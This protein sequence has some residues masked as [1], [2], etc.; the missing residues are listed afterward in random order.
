MCRNAYAIAKLQGHKFTYG[1]LGF[2]SPDHDWSLANGF[3]RESE[4]FV[5]DREDIKRL[6][7]DILVLLERLSKLYE[8]WR[9][10]KNRIEEERKRTARTERAKLKASSDVGNPQS[11]GLS[12]NENSGG[13]YDFD[14]NVEENVVRSPTKLSQES[15]MFSSQSQDQVEVLEVRQGV[16]SINEENYSF[17]KSLGSPTSSSNLQISDTPDKTDRMDLES[18]ASVE[19]ESNEKYCSVVEKLAKRHGGTNFLAAET[20]GSTKSV[21]GLSKVNHTKKKKLPTLALRS[22]NAQ[23]E[24]HE[25]ISVS[26]RESE[27]TQILSEQGHDTD[28]EVNLSQQSNTSQSTDMENSDMPRIDGKSF[29]LKGRICAIGQ[30]ESLDV[31]GLADAAAGET[32]NDLGVNN[33]TNFQPE[34]LD[35]NGGDEVGPVSTDDI[36][37]VDDP[38]TLNE[39][40]STEDLK[41]EEC[42]KEMHI[43]KE[44]ALAE[45]ERNDPISANDEILLPGDPRN[46]GQ[47]GSET[48]RDVSAC[49]G[50]KGSSENNLRRRGAPISH[51]TPSIRG[52][53]D[54]AIELDSDSPDDS[55]EMSTGG[56]ESPPVLN[57]DDAASNMTDRRRAVAM[58]IDDEATPSIK[59]MEVDDT[60]MVGEKS[61]SIYSLKE[62]KC[63]QHD[64]IIRQDYV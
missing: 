14:Q 64:L 22:G 16:N 17:Q 4:V 32:G 29:D 35:E 27:C 28:N 44:A 57:D 9:N 33:S 20:E 41:V 2:P 36:I 30:K 47:N 12:S 15:S 62:N 1:E 60:N 59:P 46:H 6:R 63:E 21:I 56:G 7:N 50:F 19:A 49:S 61:P 38:K 37:D 58:E 53:A 54:N 51:G 25:S 5:Y 42:N 18:L 45:F 55:S 10:E 26:I 39:L 40:K 43:T 34:K 3:F 11:D 8:P 48:E 23:K 13:G 24:Y 31:Q 52:S